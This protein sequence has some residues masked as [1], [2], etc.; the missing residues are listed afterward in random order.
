MAD[1]HAKDYVH[2]DIKIAKILSQMWYGK[3]T[4]HGTTLHIVYNVM[5]WQVIQMGNDS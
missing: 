5:P 3:L 1:M 4:C 2:V